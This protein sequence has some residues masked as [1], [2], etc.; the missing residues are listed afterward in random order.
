MNRIRQKVNRSVEDITEDRLSETKWKGGN[1]SH[2][3]VIVNG[4]EP[5]PGRN[6]NVLGSSRFLTSTT[7]Q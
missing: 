7:C 2:N 1:I 5:E 3:K 6:L 4:I